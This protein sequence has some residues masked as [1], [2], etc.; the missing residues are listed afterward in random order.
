MPLQANVDITATHSFITKVNIV[1]IPRDHFFKPKKLAQY[2]ISDIQP[3][4]IPEPPVVIENEPE[5][6]PPEMDMSNVQILNP[7]NRHTHD[8]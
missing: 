7:W 1:S 4:V 5:P 3:P 8:R 2:G 6:P